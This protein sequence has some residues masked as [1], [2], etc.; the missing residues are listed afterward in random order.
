MDIIVL[1]HFV[2][3][4]PEIFYGCVVM[5]AANCYSAGV[6][7]NIARDVMEASE[8]VH[9]VPWWCYGFTSSTRPKKRLEYNWKI[10]HDS[11]LMKFTF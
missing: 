3:D 1:Y 6:L 2:K 5:I 10:M 8:R 4:K 11:I 7:S 9:D